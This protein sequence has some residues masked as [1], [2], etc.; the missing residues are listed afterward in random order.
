M[1]RVRSEMGGFRAE[2]DRAIEPGMIY[3]DYIELRMRDLISEDRVRRGVR[4]HTAD[5]DALA[6]EITREPAY[7]EIAL[8]VAAVLFLAVAVV[9]SL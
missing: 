9:L 8:V 1:Q 4:A 3:G 6:G 2:V 7:V 5:V